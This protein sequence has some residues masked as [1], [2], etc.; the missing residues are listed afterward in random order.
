MAGAQNAIFMSVY[1]TS[2]QTILSPDKQLSS[3]AGTLT[4][5]CTFPSHACT[6]PS[7]GI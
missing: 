6:F 1:Y 3:Y 2:W 7:I 5:A 4:N